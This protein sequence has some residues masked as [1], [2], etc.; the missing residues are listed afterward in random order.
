[1][2]LCSIEQYIG[3]A[4]VATNPFYKLHFLVG[5]ESKV[6]TVSY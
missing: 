1:M 5:F 4:H 3:I 2:R 6:L